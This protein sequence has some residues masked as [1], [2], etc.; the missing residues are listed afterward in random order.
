MGLDISVC[1]IVKR[2]QN[3]PTDRVFRLVDNNAEYQNPFPEWTKEFE[4]DYEQ[5]YYDWDKL[6]E[7][8]GIN[9]NDYEYGGEEYGPKGC[10]MR[11]NP[12]GEEYS[13]DKELV[14]D[15]E[16]IPVKKKMI[17]VL[18][19][20]EVGYQRKGL[21]SKFYQDYDNDK[22][23]YFVWTKAELER[24]KEEYCDEPY[25]YVYG[26]GEKSGEMIY[27]KEDFQRNII[28]NFIEGEC[29]VTFDW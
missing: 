14:L 21:N 13:K 5:G 6:K 24:Y 3:E 9:I 16:K 20:E 10:F 2:K 19:Y 26:N 29:C 12:K 4:V 7:E 23:G 25:E 11:F 28:D 17:K 18:P 27:P 15:I 1:K 8:Q 22:I